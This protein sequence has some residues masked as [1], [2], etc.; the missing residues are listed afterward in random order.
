[1]LL[2]YPQKA[3][4]EFLGI[5]TACPSV[6][7]ISLPGLRCILLTKVDSD[8][9][10]VSQSVT[11]HSISLIHA[12]ECVLCVNIEDDGEIAEVPIVVTRSASRP[13]GTYI[14]YL[15]KIS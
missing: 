8:L 7:Q 14:F 12:C 13:I 10:A 9:L 6:A 1:M 5:Q 3:V 4:M 11:L 2:T 15:Q